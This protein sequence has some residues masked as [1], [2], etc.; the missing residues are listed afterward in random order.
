MQHFPAADGAPELLVIDNY[1]SF[2]FNLVQ[3]FA[4]QGAAVRVYRND[5]ITPAAALE[6]APTH[7]V[8]SP[9]PGRPDE[10]GVSLSIIA[11]FA[12]RVPLLGVCLGHQCVV[13]HFGGTIVAAP[14]LMH[15]K[16]SA[17]THTDE[18]LFAGIANPMQVGRYHSLCAEADALPAA[19]VATATTS[20]GE[21]M[22]VRHREWP[23][24]GVQFHPESVLTPDGDALLA[25]FIEG[26]KT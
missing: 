3:A 7:V 18:S 26:A 16:T 8:I 24:T 17:I 9:G 6:L 15:G 22:A 5:E 2:T 12:G 10:A 19:L 23:V 20:A 1:D 11:A 14:R 25:N 13:Q 21:L 4:A